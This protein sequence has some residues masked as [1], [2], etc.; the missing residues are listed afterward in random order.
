[1]APEKVLKRRNSIISY[2]KATK[3]LWNNYS[4]TNIILTLVNW[5]R[6]SETSKNKVKR[7]L[8]EERRRTKRIARQKVVL[9]WMR[10]K[11]TE[12]I[13]SL[14]SCDSCCCFYTK[15]KKRIFFVSLSYTK[16]WTI[17]IFFLLDIL[18]AALVV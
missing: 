13:S 15:E 5:T 14:D 18:T 6:I 8:K 4:D 10:R 16:D 7:E 3:L 17:N 9:N 2:Q 12:N 11:H 1:M